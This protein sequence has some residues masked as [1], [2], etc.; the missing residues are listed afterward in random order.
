MT[1]QSLPFSWT[2]GDKVK[3]GKR[4]RVFGEGLTRA[5]SALGH[6]K[7]ACS[8]TVQSG[9]FDQLQGRRLHR[10][11]RNHGASRPNKGKPRKVMCFGAGW[12]RLEAKLSVVKSRLQSESKLPFP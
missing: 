11:E 7:G 3:S 8:L 4:R 6:K 9:C 10:T 1:Q 5:E 2:L 12:S